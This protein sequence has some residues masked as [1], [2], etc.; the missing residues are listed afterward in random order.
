MFH[1]QEKTVEPIESVESEE[2]DGR[3]KGEDA[4]IGDE[5]DGAGDGSIRGADLVRLFTF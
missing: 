1:V 5:S 2:G 4:D 3:D